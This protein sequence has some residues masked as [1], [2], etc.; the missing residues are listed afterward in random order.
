VAFI[1]TVFLSFFFYFGIE[2][3]ATISPNFQGLISSIG[4]QDHFKSM[5][6]GVIDS[7]DVVYFISI[8]IL[9]LSFTVYNLKSI[10]S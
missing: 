7:R 9:F 4:M 6:R 1:V 10:K 3:L 8:T 5:S 2:A